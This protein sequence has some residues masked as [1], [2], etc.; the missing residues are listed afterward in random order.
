[1]HIICRGYFAYLRVIKMEYFQC[2]K[3]VVEWSIITFSPLGFVDVIPRNSSPHNSEGTDLSLRTS[4]YLLSPKLGLQ[5][6]V[7]TI[8]ILERDYFPENPKS[9]AE[10]SRLQKVTDKHQ[11]LEKHTHTHTHITILYIYESMCHPVPPDGKHSTN[12]KRSACVPVAKIL[13]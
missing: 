7:D 13:A 5:P 6:S 1:M 9:T 10:G 8:Q 11:R 4:P 2:S 3:S 12:I